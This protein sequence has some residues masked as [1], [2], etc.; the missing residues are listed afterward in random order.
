MSREEY[1][2]NPF[3]QAIEKIISD[4]KRHDDPF[5]KEI[6]TRFGEK[7]LE[8]DPNWSLRCAQNLAKCIQDLDEQQRSKSKA[9]RLVHR[10][11]PFVSGLTMC[12][13]A[14]ETAVQA[15]PAPTAVLYGGAQLI[16][17]AST[18][19]L[20]LEYSPNNDHQWADRI[21]GCFDKVLDI[22]EEIG[23]LLESYDKFYSAYGSSEPMQTLLVDCYGTI[24]RF[25]QRAFKI[26]KSKGELL[27][28]IEAFTQQ[29]HAA[30]SLQNQFH[31]LL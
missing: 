24:V 20:F 15:G 6:V 16:L 11:Q 21:A 31:R 29:T 28:F 25:W 19:S 22:I 1:K 2:K 14:F 23:T 26:L 4:I 9:R 30:C 12:T 8:D 7:L 3:A 13:K 17:Q 18:C 10:L 27:L 5:F